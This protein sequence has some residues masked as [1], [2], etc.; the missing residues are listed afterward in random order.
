MAAIPLQLA[1]LV[2]TETLE[3]LSRLF[4]NVTGIPIVIVD[5]DGH[6]LTVVE[7]PLRFCGTLVCAPGVL[8]LRR[9]QW[10][11]PEPESERQLRDRHAQ[12]KPFGHRCAGGFRDMA[13]PI[14]VREQTV[15]YAVFARSLSQ[16]PDPARFRDLARQAGLAPEVGEQVAAAAL[17]MTK[18]RIQAVAEFLQVIAEMVAGAAY[19][20]LHARQVIELEQLRDSLVHMIVHDLRTP[21]TS[22]MGGLQ[23]IV[24]SEFEPELTREFVALAADSARS[25]LEMVNTLLDINKLESG[26]LDLHREPVNFASLAQEALDQVRG[27]ALEHRHELHSEADVCPLLPADGEL[28]RRVVVNLLGN[29]IKFTPDGGR[30]SLSC[31]ADDQGLTFTVR[32]TGPGIPEEDRERIFEKFGQVQS[33]QQGRKYSTGLGLTFCKMVAEAHGG[34]IWVESEPGRG[35]AFHV[36]IPNTGGFPS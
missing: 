8:C 21:L 30:I 25:L 27:L 1:Q 15:G 18:E 33:R 6:P 3:R 26:Q 24:D 2:P 4:H 7:D 23:T 5:D 13:V 28:L 32:D 9:Q 29:A 35:S 22:I 12:S 36:W 11:V 17:V 14:V 34:R 10:D 31:A 16:E 20:S 19:D